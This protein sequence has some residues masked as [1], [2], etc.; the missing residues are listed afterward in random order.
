MSTPLYTLLDLETLIRYMR[1]CAT[2]IDFPTLIR[3]G[4]LRKCRG[5]WYEILDKTRLPWY[6]SSQAIAGRLCPAL[7]F[8]KFDRAATARGEHLAGKDIE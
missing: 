8:L 7:R 5:G 6:V 3:E 1:E 2:P 4:V